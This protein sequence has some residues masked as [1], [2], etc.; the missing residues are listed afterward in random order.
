MTF[1]PKDSPVWAQLEEYAAAERGTPLFNYRLMRGP[2]NELK[3]RRAFK[4][5]V[6]LNQLPLIVP[7]LGYLLGS[8]V[9]LVGLPMALV[10]HRHPHDLLWPLVDA[11]ILAAIMSLRFELPQ[12]RRFAAAVRGYIE[13]PTASDACSAR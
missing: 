10:G 6:L 4:A 3:R 2:L 1:P 11:V 9:G 8:C 7:L 12:R 5:L 13:H